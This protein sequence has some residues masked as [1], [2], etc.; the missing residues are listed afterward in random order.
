[1]SIEDDLKEVGMD[2]ECFEE[3]K[4]AIDV[5]T[6]DLLVTLNKH[7]DRVSIPALIAAIV[8]MCKAISEDSTAAP[9]DAMIE[10]THQGIEAMKRDFIR[11]GVGEQINLKG[12]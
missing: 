12:H 10:M 7:D 2:M 3:F 8:S 11:E 1:M 4:K 5:A 9:F 6:A